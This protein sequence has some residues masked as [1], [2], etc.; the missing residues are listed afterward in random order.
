MSYRTEVTHFDQARQVRSAP[1]GGA[2]GAGGVYVEGL[3]MDG[4]AWKREDKE[5]PAS[6]VES[7]PKKLFSPLPILHVTAAVSTAATTAS[8]STGDAGGGNGSEPGQGGGGGCYACPCYKY[9]CRTDRY[10]VFSVDLPAG[11]VRT[12]VHWGLRGLA[13][14]CSTD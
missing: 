6:V 14:L 13:L 7:A 2:G 1:A 10:F 11:P 9:A 5:G 4:A 12:P 3:H 8:T